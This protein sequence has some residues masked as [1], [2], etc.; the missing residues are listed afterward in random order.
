M[1]IYIVL[2]VIAAAAIL[3]RTE[4]FEQRMGWWGDITTDHM[5]ARHMLNY[6]EI[7]RLGHPA[8]GLGNGIYYP[9]YYYYFIAGLQSLLGSYVSVA[10]LL[11]IIHGL[12]TFAM[13]GAARLLF[14]RWIGV[15]AAV[16]YAFSFRMIHVALVT[17]PP[18][19][20]T[21]LALTLLAGFVWAH[22][23]NNVYIRALMIGALI[24]LSTWYY[25]LFVFVPLALV[26]EIIRQNRWIVRMTM[27]VFVIGMCIFAYWPVI[28]YFTPDGWMHTMRHLSDGAEPY[29]AVGVWR[30]VRPVWV[31]LYD[32]SGYDSTRLTALVVSLTALVVM[33]RNRLRVYRAPLIFVGLLLGYYMFFLMFV[34][35]GIHEHA[36]HI[37]KPLGILL[38]APLF[39]TLFTKMDKRSWV[40]AIASGS[41]AIGAMVVPDS[42]FFYPLDQYR[43]TESV[44][45]HISAEMKQSGRAG[46]F[47]LVTIRRGIRTNDHISYWDWLERI[48]G[49]R[50]MEVVPE[51]HNLREIYDG[52]NVMLICLDYPVEREHEC[53]SLFERSALQAR[54]PTQLKRI[55]NA[56]LFMYEQADQDRSL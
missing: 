40:A 42:L 21:P 8:T 12:G 47:S 54:Q 44:A 6:E 48:E 51:Y 38:I 17:T 56:S 1:N 55:E 53:T 49:D 35:G 11:V 14:D 36:L 19:V 32:F 28:S 22:K 41:I 27:T 26:I 3:I 20:A 34:R 25:G 52:N 15:I 10:L 24:F 7:P 29:A 5:V 18:F 9:P 13:Y 43:Q 4:R 31:Y 23:N 37:V 50:F 2:G 39:R 30:F 46:R 33:M 45:R 16:V